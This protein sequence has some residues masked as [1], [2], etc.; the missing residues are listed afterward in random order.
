[1]MVRA[2]ERAYAYAKACGIIGKSFVGRRV[3]ALHP[4][5]RLSELDRL[6]FSS[7]ARDL[8]ERELL[9][10]LERR[11]LERSVNAII[12]IFN[13]FDNPP[14]LLVHLIRVYE[15]ADLKTALALIAA[16]P[17]AS[18][19]ERPPFTPLGRYG[20][21]RFAAWPDAGAMLEGTEFDF[22]LASR[23]P[24]SLR[25]KGD[26]LETEL[27]CLYYRRLWE[28]LLRLKKTDRRAAEK[29][30]REEISLR[31]CA[32][33]LRLRTY[34]GM[35]AE[36]VK[37]HLISIEGIGELSAD[38]LEALE[39][40]LDNRV[41]WERWGRVEFLNPEGA[42]VWQA[43]P[44]YFQNAVSEYLYKL[45]LRSFRRNPFSVDTCFCFIKLKQFEEDLLTSDAEGL[46][47][48]MSSK[49]VFG[50]L[51]ANL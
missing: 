24:A 11:L 3:S 15:Y 4:V 37:A 22:L 14:P 39:L 33:A 35:R 8:P 7:N 27:D 21:V 43:D 42:G 28:Y 1:M 19:A 5:T 48:G 47:L 40:P 29:I 50:I 12:S 17:E 45:A 34:Y 44:R 36:Q 49:D 41:E 13:C 18:G 6:V 30:T 31:N 20:T 32:W 46:G 23:T 16:G 10:D 2:G 38:A 51:E 9:P 25:D 26:A